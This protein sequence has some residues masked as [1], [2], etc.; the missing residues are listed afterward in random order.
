MFENTNT[1]ATPAHITVH[2]SEDDGLSGLSL[3]DHA[4][5]MDE[6]TLGWRLDLLNQEVLSLA[7]TVTTAGLWPDWAAWYAVP[8][9]DKA[10]HTAGSTVWVYT[11]GGHPDRM[12]L[13]PIPHDSVE[14]LEYQIHCA[15][16]Q[17]NALFAQLLEVGAE[18]ERELSVADI[19]RIRE[20][21]EYLS[22]A[23][24]VDPNP[25]DPEGEYIT[26]KRVARM[27][28]L[29]KSAVRRLDAAGEIVGID[30]SFG[31]RFYLAG[32]FGEHGPVAALKSVVGTLREVMSDIE[33][34]SWLVTPQAL[35]VGPS[36]TPLYEMR[37]GDPLS[38]L[39]AAIRLAQPERTG[40]QVVTHVYWLEPGQDEGS[41]EL[42]TIGYDILA[43]E[44]PDG[45][46]ITAA[47]GKLRWD[48]L[49]QDITRDEAVDRFTRHLQETLPAPASS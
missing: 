43:E 14:S 2:V 30:G 9:A 29:S 8:R 25:A 23:P 35:T 28:G 6:L 40:P 32:Q 37:C 11:D 18:A 41:P 33:I 24:L 7:K 3:E 47:R 44:V 38:A 15:T 17:L 21:G 4:R 48:R 1:P 49:Y 10:F 12:A 34:S 45:W 19:E 5:F 16:A 26:A 27:T 46:V 39:R 42:A 13:V 22:S 31:K 20:A 36:T